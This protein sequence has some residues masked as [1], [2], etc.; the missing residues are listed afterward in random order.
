MS[1]L[2]EVLARFGIEA[3]PKP[4][5]KMEAG[6]DHL[7]EKL[8]QLVEGAGVIEAAKKIY[9]FAEGM[10][11]AGTELEH[12]SKR[13]GLSTDSLQ[14]WRHAAKLS[15][16]GADELTGA[17]SILQRHLADAASGGKEGVA[18]FEKLK[19][20][21][22]DTHG[23]IRSLDELLPELAEKIKNAKGPTEAAGLAIQAFG[24]SGSLML[25]FLKEG[26]E[27]VAKLREEFDEL[28]GGMSEENIKAADELSSNLDRLNLTMFSLQS[29]IAGVLIPIINRLVVSSIETRKE[30]I[31]LADGTNI[32]EAAIYTLGVALGLMAVHTIIAFAPLIATAAAFAVA[33]A[34]I[35]LT[36][37]DMIS[38]FTGGKSV[39]GDF[40]DE[41]LGV[42][43]AQQ[44]V[45]DLR[46]AWQGMIK[47][48]KDATIAVKEF[49][50]LEL[51]AEEKAY[52]AKGNYEQTAATRAEG[53][54]KQA[55]NLA[56]QGIVSRMDGESWDD[57]KARFEQ[58][59]A[60]TMHGPRQAN[61]GGSGRPGRAVS[62]PGPAGA[63][64][65][66]TVDAR[67]SAVI[68]VAPGTDRKQREDI[69]KAVGEVIDQRNRETVA[70]LD[71]ESLPEF[72]FT[73]PG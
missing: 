27:G 56:R 30:F 31:R 24:R 18:F 60:Y 11:E 73:P 28:G 16:V 23:H 46:D 3:D 26:K 44:M 63:G 55:A 7:V 51:D 37:D 17:L 4:L 72:G 53:A 12:V 67:T 65:G 70:A 69:R 64:A 71:Q 45:I 47:F 8:K 54:R 1:V 39:I 33:I 41:L 6:V 14:A 34:F 49:L 19:L 58:D 15:G 22:K 42:G 38:L 52:S 40:I 20:K 43:T 13:L 48:I 32:W 50:G 59:R 2:R 66:T 35:V 68:Q 57:A 9:E 21:V 62:V 36:V 10:A 29:R 25:P 61:V 5:E